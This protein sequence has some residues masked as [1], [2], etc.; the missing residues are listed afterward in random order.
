MTFD[1]KL[2]RLLA[3]RIKDLLIK[4]KN[5]RILVTVAGIP[6]SGKSTVAY[7]VRDWLNNKCDNINSCVVGMDGF[8]LYRSQLQQ[9][10]DPQNAFI[11]RGAP[12]T[13]DVDLFLYFV[14]QLRKS[15]CDP[16]RGDIYAPSFDHS[17]KDP[18]PNGTKIDKL[19]LVVIIEG[20]YLLLDIPP[21]NEISQLVDERWFIGVDLQV[22]R[23]RV[24]KRHVAAGIE[25]S[26]DDAYN[27]VDTNDTINAQ[28]ILL[29]IDKRVDFMIEE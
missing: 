17:V 27:R 1:D 11:R 4:S 20:L 3:G 23:D 26:L 24:A 28:L 8:H 16:Q 15:C 7:K 2:S 12:F 6:G 29:N 13:F 5:D 9:M 25:K 14:R 22:S 18:T 19:I 10:D 21:W